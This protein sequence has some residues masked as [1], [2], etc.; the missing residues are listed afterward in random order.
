QHRA[1]DDRLARGPG[2]ESLGAERLVPLVRPGERDRD[3]RFVVNGTGKGTEGVAQR[4]SID[5]FWLAEPYRDDGRTVGARQC[6]RL[7]LASREADPLERSPAQSHLGGN[8]A[9][10][11]DEHTERGGLA[12]G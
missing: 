4:G 8:L 9:R 6:E 5:R 11:P 2:G 10:L 3:P 1:L 12:C 7:P